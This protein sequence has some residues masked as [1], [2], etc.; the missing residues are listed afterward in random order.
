MTESNPCESRV[1]PCPT[2]DCPR[3]AG[4]EKKAELSGIHLT[5]NADG[6]MIGTQL[7]DCGHYHGR[8][9]IMSLAKTQ[10]SPRLKIAFGRCLLCALGGLARGS[11]SFAW[12]ACFPVKRQEDGVPSTPYRLPLSSV[13]R[14]LSSVFR[15]LRVSVVKTRAKQSQ[16]RDG[17]IRA[18]CPVGKGLG[19]KTTGCAATK[20]KPIRGVEIA[21]PAFARAGL[22][23]G[24]PAVTG[25][26]QG[27][28]TRPSRPA[29][30]G[31]ACRTKPIL[32]GRY[33]R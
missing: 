33:E 32:E 25:V 16:S 3:P 2:G 6:R 10:R 28:A 23:C 12:F 21:S 1:N 26:C 31:K 27:P 13:L 14:P 17:R 18:N 9:M 19:D 20:T 5:A 15:A 7:Q 22:A 24:L 4:T 11:S 29:A 30:E 8:E